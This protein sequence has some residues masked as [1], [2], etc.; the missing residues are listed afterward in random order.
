[1]ARSIWLA[2][3]AFLLI[4]GAPATA[5]AQVDTVPAQPAAPAAAGALGTEVIAT[6]AVD[7]LPI[8]AGTYVFVPDE[9]DDIG[10]MVKEA[11]HHMFFAI[12][13][14]AGKRLR[15]A[16][17]PIDRIIIQ[18]PPDS[19]YISLRS[20]EPPVYSLRN[21]EF[22]P[23]TREDGEVVQVKTE[24]SPGVIDQF[25]H[26][27]DGDKQMLYRLRPDGTL[28]L[29]VTVISDKLKEPFKYTW[30]YRPAEAGQSQEGGGGAAAASGPVHL[31]RPVHTFSIVARD[32]DSG[33]IGVAVQSHWF[34]VGALVPW[35]V[36]GVGAV[37]TQ[38]FVDPSYGP[39]GLELM[40]AGKTA[41]Q[42]LAALLVA[43]EHPDVRQVAMV[44]AHGNVAAHTG[45][46][47][48]QNAGHITGEGFSV[49]ANMMLNTTVPA[50]MAKAYRT[51]KGDLTE[52]LM[53]A[54][55]AAQA[56]G[57]DIRGSQ[58]AAIL[59]VSGDT[60]LMPWQGRIV[61][62]RVE[63]NPHPVQELRRLVTLNRAYARMNAGDD[64]MTRGDIRG[65]APRV[66]R[67]R[68]HGAR[69]VQQW[70]DAVL[71]RSDSGQPG[72]GR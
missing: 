26:S 33:E 35:A 20:D 27:D 72:P 34:S 10:P 54:L 59:V 2:A 71:A 56:E 28:E 67:R 65:R 13:G 60:A 15:N 41:Q 17:K 38:S 19:V 55:E 69:F 4:A 32:P 70:R 37:A 31:G 25:F 45:G 14:I 53:A 11:V 9:S 42:A 6:P 48:I 49:Q 39:L 43:D 58:A 68:G 57:G 63:D 50:A 30:V 47:D 16:N 40:K 22:M 66:R 7:S 23:Y 62:L 5:T 52:R 21:G 46:S 1:M 3:G 64:A 51:T 8:P 61:D 18:Y 36:P 24:L 29:S 12:R 44:D